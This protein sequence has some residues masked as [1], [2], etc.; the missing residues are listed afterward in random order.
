MG[1]GTRRPGSET[2]SP[3]SYFLKIMRQKFYVIGI[4]EVGRGPLAG[5][6]LV[7]A[8]ALSSESLKKLKKIGKLKDSKALSKKQRFEWVKH[9][10]KDRDII[11]KS[12]RCFPSTIDRLNIS[13]SANLAASKSYAK[14]MKVLRGGRESGKLK[15]GVKISGIFLDGGLFIKNR[16][17]S[18]ELGAKTIIRGD[19]KIPAIMVASI[20]AKVTRDRYMEKLSKSFPFYGFSENMGYGTRKHML[21]IRKRGITPHHRLT[22]IS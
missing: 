22:F 16:F 1:K 8:C 7:T 20:H 21:A 14:V 9:F 13:S 11:L 18:G 6:V 3:A 15:K 4:D 17:F 10:R 12:S 19:E 5:P 2:Q